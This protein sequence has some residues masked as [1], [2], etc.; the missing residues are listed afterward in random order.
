MSLR[1][2]FYYIN[3]ALLFLFL[4]FFKIP[5][6]LAE[7]PIPTPTTISPTP[8]PEETIKN[9]ESNAWQKFLNWLFGL[10][11]K[12]DYQIDFRSLDVKNQDMTNYSDIKTSDFDQKHSFAGSRLSDINSQ[13]CLKGNVIK[14]VILKIS[15]YRDSD[16]SK[17][18]LSSTGCTVKPLNDTTRT[19]CTT[20][21]IDDLAHYFVQLNQPVYCTPNSNQ[22][23][24]LDS[25]FIT[26]VKAITF[27]KNPI[28]VSELDCYQKIYDDFYITPKGNTDNNEENAKKIVQTPINVDSQNPGENTTEIKNRV[29]DNFTPDN[30]PIGTGGLYGL[31]PDNWDEDYSEA[32]LGVGSGTNNGVSSGTCN[33]LQSHCEG[34]S[35]YGALGLSQSGKNYQE[36]LKF[37]YGNISLKTLNTSNLNITVNVS[38]GDDCSKYK[39]LNLETYLSGLGEMPNYWGS[40]SKG[41]YE[42]MKALVVAARTFAYMYTENLTK[43]IC[44]TS[45]CQVFR[46]N[47]I[48]TMPYLDQAIKETSGQIIVDYNNKTPFI[49]LYA[50]SFCG[51]SKTVVYSNHTNP[52][53]NGYEYELKARN[54]EQPFC[55]NN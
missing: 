39:P 52:S 25:N 17:I 10:F 9:P 50:R 38:S 33:A 3:L 41:G 13:N 1:S 27:S 21:S 55:I 5:S 44:S 36:I 15:G 54:G 16:L 14:N 45:N 43:P 49:T 11:V 31:R 46:C 23:T 32:D 28:P 47:L 35:V 26:A 12:T 20:I 24:N 34:M 42:T 2:V 51:P 29:D 4:P 48:K 22:L 19:N 37:Y 53:V 30:Y 6:V 18:C 7:T 40:P 8:S